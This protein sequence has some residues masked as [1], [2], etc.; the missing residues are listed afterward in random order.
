ML[1]MLRILGVGSHQIVDLTIGNAAYL[2]G[3]KPPLLARYLLYDY[4]SSVNLVIP[5]VKIFLP[6]D[7][8]VPQFFFSN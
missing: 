1:P 6:A 3:T 2:L 4:L 7:C 5:H 8:E